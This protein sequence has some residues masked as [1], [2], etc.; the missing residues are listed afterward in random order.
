MSARTKA[1]KRAIDM[2]Y[3]SDVLVRPLPQV[4]AAE[5]NRAATEPERRA[6]WVYAAEIV[7]GVIDNQAEIDEKIATTAEGWTLDRMPHV[8][9]AALRVAIWEICFN[10]EVP[11]PVAISEAANLVQDLSTEDSAKFISGVLGRIAEMTAL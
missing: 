6:S 9:R 3:L 10:P 2:V 1:R 5:A 4:L 7:Q 8:D 11:A